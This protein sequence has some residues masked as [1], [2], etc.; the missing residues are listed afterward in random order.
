MTEPGRHDESGGG[1]PRAGRFDDGR[2]GRG[3]G[4]NNDEVGHALE[5]VEACSRALPA[6]HGRARVDEIDA[7]G[8]ARRAQVA[9]DGEANRAFAVAGSDEGDGGRCEQFIETVRG[10]DGR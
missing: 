1:S 6:D 9:Q 3:R 8:Q 7:A 10:H 4:C 2:H 5:I